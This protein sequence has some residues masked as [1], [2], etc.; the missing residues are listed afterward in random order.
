MN[1]TTSRLTKLLGTASFLT[2][3]NSLDAHGQAAQ[4]PPSA[5]GQQVAQAQMAQPAPEMLPEQVLITGS[6]IRGTAAVGV[7]VTNLSVQ[8]IRQTGSITT[9]DLFRSIPQFNVIPG[10]VGTQAANVERGT[11][12]NLRQLDTGSAPRSLMMID[13]VRY[14]AQ[15]MG[16]CQIDPSIIP[17][18]AIDRIDLLLDGA[19]ATYGSDAI[20]G[21]INIILRRGYDGAQT[22][23][24]FT[25]GA[26]GNTKY[27]ASQLWGRTWDGGDIT[28][29]YQ[30]YNVS[31]THGNFNSK[32]TFDFTPWGLDDRT[33]LASSAPG[34]ISTG[35]PAA[36]DPTNYPATNGRNCTNCFAIP[37]GTGGN[38]NPINGGLGPLA[39]SSA[40]TLNWA[41]FN[42][43]A[44]SGPINGTRNEFNPYSI[45]D[46]SAASQYVG[47]S[48]TIDQRLTRDIS[49]YGEGFY[50]M[51][52]S[53]FIN[54]STANQLTLGVPTFNPY[55]PAGAPNGLRVSYNFSFDTPS[56]TS[57]WA[58]AQRYLLG[59][60]IALPG[61][62]AAQVYYSLTRDAEYNHVVGAVNR[63]AV[64]AALG[65]T[66]PPTPASGTAPT[67]GTFT[68]PG[69]V[70]YL[71]LFCDATM[72]QCNAPSTLAYIQAYNE[73]ANEAFW[74]NEKAIK[75][76]GPLF[77]LPGGQVKAA[78]GLS[79]TSYRFLIQS[80][81][82]TSTAN[83]AMTLLRDPESRRVWASFAQLNVPLIG[84]NNALP[85][86]RKLELEGSWRHD[87]YS[88]VGGTSN[89]KVAFNWE[90]S[91]D[92]GLTFRG[93]WG[94]SFRAPSFG[95]FSPISNVAWNGWGLQ[96]APGAAQFN[97]N[98]TIQIACSGGAPPPGSAAE[99][100]FAAGFA[101]GSQPAG[102]SLNGGG[103][104][105]V[106]A[107]FRTYTNQENLTL[108]PELSTNWGFGF[109]FA[110][111][112]F[113]RGLDIQATWYSVKINGLLINFG[114]PTT[115]RLN[116]PELG[117]AYLVPSDVGCPVAQNAHPEQC[118][119][120]QDMLTLALAHPTNQVP[121]GARTLI[122]WIND[123][124]TQ[125][126]GW[127]KTQGIDWTIS[128]D[129]DLGDIGAW[130]AGM[131]G[132]YYLSQKAARVAGGNVTDVLYHTDLSSVG[133]IAQLGV[134]SLPRF[135]YRA[136]LGWSNGPYSV[137]GFMDY[138]GHFFHTQ[139]APPNVNFQ[140]LAAGGTV[141]GG[142][143]PCAISNY[144]NI[145][146]S[147]YTF[148]IALGYDTGDTPANE[149]MRNISVQLVIQNI[150]DKHAPFEYRTATGGGNPCACDIS[151]SLFGR[152]TQ[153]RVVKTW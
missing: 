37:A 7:P 17:T 46:Y 40:A 83:T 93:S 117:F 151:K 44:N 60:N 123:G 109:D 113:L 70:P 141:G 28:L 73:N 68:K 19:S 78:I 128:Y 10:P 27:L 77:D 5:Q 79:Y 94:T 112:S 30:W 144:T 75:A 55:Y 103:K 89:P 96:N 104:A 61:D 32:Y 119:A 118:E 138:Q 4:A 136:R 114:N 137:T 129:W 125:N 1:P 21:V 22:E 107:H 88:D 26:G 35:A 90:V 67:I 8:D 34:T 110:P 48:V 97:N 69:V 146:P 43:A 148:D 134:E 121:A 59:F 39:P 54:N 56:I 153:I 49:F 120:F 85:L 115:N 66:M 106:D 51:R 50:G 52:R 41:T 72:F 105:A 101:C 108:D 63:A 65:W 143:F 18:V 58:S 15:G 132:T 57:S 24:G 13:G 126:R 102:L 20:G 23:V 82:E 98:A 116:D 142:T 11:R 150:F 76:D 135:K 86:I 62:W 111:T 12:V 80:N 74:I 91:E 25:T 42:V 31:P 2:L 47:G 147:Y 99:K 139:T 122:F 45:T 127:Q 133:G 38:F 14:P 152:Q 84:D 149:Y 87:Q 36:T 131:S 53:Q 16:L 71:N 33:P 29:G 6:L 130:N 124:G 92:L 81:T 100:L 64:S 95:E 9:S 3:A 140:C 145:E